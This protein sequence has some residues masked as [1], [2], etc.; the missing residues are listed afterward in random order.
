MK[1]QIYT[2]NTKGFIERVLIGEFNEL[3]KLISPVGEFITTSLPQ[4]LPFHKPRWNGNGWVEGATQT[5][6]DEIT[7]PQPLTPTLEQRIAELENTLL[8]LLEVL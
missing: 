8:N 1:K 7:K 6:I 4:P 2:I 5:E 3:G